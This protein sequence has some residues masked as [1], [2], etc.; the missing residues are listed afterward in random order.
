MGVSVM[1]LSWAA[2]GTK[3]SALRKTLKRIAVGTNENAIDLFSNNS[4]LVRAVPAVRQ[5]QHNATTKGVDLSTGENSRALDTKA[6]SPTEAEKDC[7]CFPHRTNSPKQHRPGSVMTQWQ[8]TAHHT[9]GHRFPSDDRQYSRNLKKPITAD[10]PRQAH[11]SAPPRPQP[12]RF[13]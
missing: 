5:L 13:V 4:C 12:V 3:T 7:C 11:H 1:S 9:P 10:A 2:R 6:I 8:A